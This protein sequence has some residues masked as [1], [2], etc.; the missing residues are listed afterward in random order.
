MKQF[1]IRFGNIL[2]I[3]AALSSAL[4]EANSLDDADGLATEISMPKGAKVER[5]LAYGPDDKQTMDVYL[6]EHAAAAPVIFM[7]HG[8][9]WMVGDKAAD[10]VVAN[11][12]ARWLPRG[13]IVVSTNYRLLPA[14]DPLVQANDVAKALSFAQSK[15]KSWGGDPTRFILM[16]HSAGAHLVSLLAADTGIATRQGAKAWL[17]T[18][19]LDSASLDVVQTMEAKHMRFYD[20]VFKQDPAY[21]RSVSPLHRLT[22]I[23]GPMLLVC[24]SQRD[25][26]C[27]QARHF[28]AKVTSS[29]G[30]ITILPIALSHREIN[31]NLGLAGKYTEGVESFMHSLGLP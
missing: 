12:V 21:W 15:A 28:A 2:F 29:G 7:V 4:A 14:A 1:A 3:L 23:P 31:K 26:A 30:R 25:D 19:A 10:A 13:F 16:G 24:S 20:R 27:P 5:D 17:G 6:P 9:A 22:G 11:K 18:V 8:G